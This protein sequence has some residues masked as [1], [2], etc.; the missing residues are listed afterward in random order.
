MVPQPPLPSTY[1]ARTSCPI[2]FFFYNYSPSPIE[3]EDL[4]SKPNMNF[5]LFTLSVLT[6]MAAAAPVVDIHIHETSFSSLAEK[7]VASLAEKRGP[8]D[9]CIDLEFPTEPAKCPEGMVS[10]QI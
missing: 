6:A 3:I 1:E 9:T 4:S 5:Q 8:Y 7:P 10:C 2:S